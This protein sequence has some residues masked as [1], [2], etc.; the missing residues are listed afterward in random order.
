MKLNPEQEI[1]AA[2]RDG[3]FAVLAGPGS[4]KTTVL[5]QRYLRLLNEG[6]RQEDVLSLSFTSEAAKNMRSRVE[7]TGL[8]L[9]KAERVCGF[10]TFHSLALSF[11]VGEHEHFP[12]ELA[13][14]PLATG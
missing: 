8:E 13:A 9:P 3:I 5:T 10:L 12:F 14:F 6:N 11:A 7:A 4:G 1:A 2:A